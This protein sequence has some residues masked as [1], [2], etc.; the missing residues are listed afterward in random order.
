MTRGQAEEKKGHDAVM[1]HFTEYPS[2]SRTV[3]SSLSFGIT[4]FLNNQPLSDWDDLED[5]YLPGS[6]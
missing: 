5:S 1:S 6:S 2:L 3:K 4:V